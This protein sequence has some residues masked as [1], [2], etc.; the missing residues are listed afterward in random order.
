[1]V[2]YYKPNKNKCVPVFQVQLILST[3]PNVAEWGSKGTQ[4]RQIDGTRAASYTI[5]L[6][7]LEK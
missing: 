2:N 6:F 4:A 5:N 1:M 7:K 3:T